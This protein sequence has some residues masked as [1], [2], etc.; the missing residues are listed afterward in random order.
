MQIIAI[1]LVGSFLLNFLWENA[2][3][4]LY[5]HHLGETITQ[6]VLII[7]TLGDV[8]ILSLF[9]ALWWYIP[10]LRRHYTFVIPLGLIV[11]FAIEK[12]ALG[13]GR[14]AYGP[15]MPIVPL[16]NI[17]FSPMM[18]LATTGLILIL[19][20]RMVNSKGNTK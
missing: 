7:A 9:V 8:L 20:L 2:H 10:L 18:Q 19:I 11:A 3:A 17:G 15:E 12:Y 6:K 1:T 14:W 13:V 4:H 5:K 16:L